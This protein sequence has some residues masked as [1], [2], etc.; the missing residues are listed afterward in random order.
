LAGD[1]PSVGVP[2]TRLVRVEMRKMLDTRAGR[3][4][5]IG[6]GVVIATALV[7]M[8]FNNGG[9]HPL[10]EYL[11]ATMMPQ[12]IILPVVGILAV[13]SEWSQRTGLVTFSLEP[14]RMR[15]SWAKFTAAMIVGLGA[16]VFST[17][18]AAVAHQAAISVRGYSGDWSIDRLALF[19][20]ALYI[21]LGMAQGVGFGMLFR[22]TPAAIVAYFIVPTAWT[23][24]GELVSWLESASQWLDLDRTMQPL[25]TGSLTGEQ[26]AQLSAS[27]GLW[28][29]L[30]LG[31][32][33][34][35]L[36][37]AEIK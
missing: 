34:W 20:A 3:W 10:G 17:A 9:Q 13:T 6:I 37:R 2:F 4:L 5:L 31:L 35:R 15:V 25:F 14:R 28:V 29:I 26:W 22:N 19:G 8:F 30:P 16:V 21:L 18:L 12:A 7:I 11:R 27:V 36:S 23:I 32:G 33:L 1:R 24:L